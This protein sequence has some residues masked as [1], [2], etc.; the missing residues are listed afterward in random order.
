MIRH[1]SKINPYSLLDFRVFPLTIVYKKS[2]NLTFSLMTGIWRNLKLYEQVKFTLLYTKREHLLT[3]SFIVCEIAKFRH[4]K[5]W[6]KML[7]FITRERYSEEP[8]FQYPSGIL[9]RH[10]RHSTRASLQQKAQ[11]LYVSAKVNIIFQTHNNF[12]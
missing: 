7:Y 11:P 10:I 3:Y 6:A 12:K 4:Q 9:S 2:E 8:L 5:K 1:F